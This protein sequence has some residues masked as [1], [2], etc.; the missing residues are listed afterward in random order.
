MDEML[1][2]ALMMPDPNAPPAPPSSSVTTTT[3]DTVAGTA[4]PKSRVVDGS[5]ANE[6]RVQPRSIPKKRNEDRSVQQFVANVWSN[7]FSAEEHGYVI[8][9][10]RSQIA[11][12]GN[13]MIGKG[14]ENPNN[15]KGAR[16]VFNGIENIHALR[17]SYLRL[18]RLAQDDNFEGDFYAAVVDS[19]FLNAHYDP[20]RAV[21]KL[22]VPSLNGKRIKLWTSFFFRYDTTFI[23]DAR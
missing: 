20:A 21:G 6:P 15:Y 4:P 17:T 16:V 13:A 2:E 9:D 18:V 12:M 10:A 19:G 23:S 5:L 11:A 14:T 22:M 7:I 8:M 1:V 3:A